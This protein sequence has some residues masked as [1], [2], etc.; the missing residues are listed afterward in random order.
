MSKTEELLESIINNL[1][2]LDAI[3]RMQ[4]ELGC[5]DGEIIGTGRA[6]YTQGSTEYSLSVDS[7][8]FALIDIP[9][10]EGNEKQYEEIIKKSLE[11]AHTIFYVNGSGKK[12]EK[13]TLSKIKNYMRDGTAV[14]AVF[15][16]H[17]K[18]KK[19]RIVGI[20]KTYAEELREAYIKQQEIVGQ[21]EG[22][23]RSFL[24]EN[25]KG[26]IS[27]NG[28][29]AFCATAF[30]ENRTTIKDEQE[31]GLRN[32]QEKYLREYSGSIDSM[33]TDSNIACLERVIE[34]RATNF[35]HCIEEENIKKLRNR[36]QEM[37]EKISCLKTVE[38]KKINGFI[39]VCFEYQDAI[40]T[41]K[42][43]CLSEIKHIGREAVED[44]FNDLL[45]E[46]FELVESNEGVKAEVIHKRVEDRKESV[47]QKIQDY[48]NEK[49]ERATQNFY[50]NLLEAQSRMEKDL[51]REQIKFS[52]ILSAENVSISK[53]FAQKLKYNKADF[54]KHAKMVL[55][56]IC[57]FAETG[58]LF[59][60]DIGLIVGAAVGAVWGIV[61]AIWNAFASKKGKID[62][63][64]SK[65][66]AEIDEQI[67]T[68][69]EQLICELKKLN[70]EE[71]IETVFNELFETIDKQKMSLRKIKYLLNT[72]ESELIET[73]I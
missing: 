7:K 57:S 24:G 39:K 45:A 26:S 62:R 34:Q 30:N 67:D 14:F 11:K 55:A 54:I 61:S 12:P 43:G 6:D 10:I 48:V 60:K 21:T 73:A 66:K 52:V 25:F 65:I 35:E 28:L 53:D 37:L 41:A 29:L 70:Y 3:N 68:V 38:S 47:V 16:T 42:D 5:V 18:A 19:K 15:N 72:V 36:Q 51:F 50:D 59:S 46:L 64:K 44:A 49:M 27:V 23:L 8:Q 2:G 13:E 63:A 4:S 9:G 31:K 1:N 22:Q 17:C 69:S 40:T 20:D 71:K 58:M 33:L 56:S 32:D